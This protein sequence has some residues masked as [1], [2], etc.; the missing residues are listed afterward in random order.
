[1]P[2]NTNMNGWRFNKDSARIDMYYEG[3]AVAYMNATGV[4]VSGTALT[5]NRIND[6]ILFTLGTDSDVALV[7]RT[8]IL[9]ANT[10]LTGAVVGTPVTPAVAANSLI[11]SNVTAD[12]DILI[13]AQTGGNTNA[14][15]WV[16]ASAK[17]TT[18]YNNVRFGAVGMFGLGAGAT[19]T[20]ASGVLTATRSYM[21]MDAEGA[22]STDQLD[23]IT[24]PGTPADG[25]LL[26]LIPNTTDTITVDDANINLGAATRA[27]APGGSLLLRYD[28]GESQWTELVF[29]A[30]AD[31]V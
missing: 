14:Y 6:N 18:L 7:N 12:G 31:N 15:V 30:A 24:G 3:T 17:V 16:D 27:V 22:G 10:A 1:M 19:A 2:N 26:L 20:I 23:S 9:G 29:V 13:A 4:Y 28:G 5:T 25:D 8:T 11:L 21:V